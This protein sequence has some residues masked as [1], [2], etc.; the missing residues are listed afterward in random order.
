MNL[1]SYC[2]PSF[3]LYPLPYY[4]PFSSDKEKPTHSGTNL[5]HPITA[6]LAYPLTLKLHKGN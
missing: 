6:G 1:H 4:L 2:A 3:H 5:A